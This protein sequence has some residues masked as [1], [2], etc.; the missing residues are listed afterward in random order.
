MGIML[1]HIDGQAM[2]GLLLINSVRKSLCQCQRTVSISI[3]KG[4]E[5]NQINWQSVSRR[6][7]SFS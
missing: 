6:W 1:I 5:M 3:S 4:R 7:Q 2:G